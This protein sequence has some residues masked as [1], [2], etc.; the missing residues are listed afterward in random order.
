[1]PNI[2]Y[3]VH[4]DNSTIP[5]TK[6]LPKNM[7]VFGLGLRVDIGYLLGFEHAQADD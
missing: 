1:M 2:Q 5:N 6:V 3:V 4:P 7:L